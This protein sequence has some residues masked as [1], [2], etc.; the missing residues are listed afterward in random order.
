MKPTLPNEDERLSLSTHTDEF[1][2]MMPMLSSALADYLKLFPDLETPKHLFMIDASKFDYFKVRASDYE[3]YLGARKRLLGHVLAKVK[4]ADCLLWLSDSDGTYGEAFWEYLSGVVLREKG[5]LVTFYGLKGG[6]IFAYNVPEYL[7]KLRDAN[8]LKKGAFA[9]ELEM[10]RPQPSGESLTQ[11]DRPELMC[12]EAE[13]SEMRTRSLS[14]KEGVGQL[15]KYLREEE[16]YTH[17]FVTGPFTKPADI[18]RDWVGLISCDEDGR[19]I[20]QKGTP[21]RQP[22]DETSGVVKNIIKATLLRN[23]TF[24]ERCTLVGLTVTNVH[25]ASLNEFVEKIENIDIDII[26][27]CLKG[28]SLRCSSMAGLNNERA[29]LI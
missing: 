17:G 15:R 25:G 20:F 8:F 28:H 13:S 1:R 5:Y 23:L 14:D 12:I 27:D 7:E 10:L 3:Y 16:R 2:G 18:D 9:E 29:H 19:L 22:S 4:A 26:L 6:D 11:G 24:E 21:Y